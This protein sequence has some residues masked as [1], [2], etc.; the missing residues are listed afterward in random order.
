MSSPRQKLP[1]SIKLAD[2][3]FDYLKKKPERIIKRGICNSDI[4]N[5]AELLYC[6]ITKWGLWEKML[7]ENFNSFLEEK[8]CHE[9]F[10]KHPSYTPKTYEYV[11]HM[12]H[13]IAFNGEDRFKET[14]LYGTMKKLY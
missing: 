11:I 9:I 7:K 3:N 14:Y 1:T 6:N 12:M 2:G 8:R 5:L 10:K 4:A 13:S